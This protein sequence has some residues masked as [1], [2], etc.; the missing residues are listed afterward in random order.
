LGQAAVMVVLK[1]HGIAFS[2]LEDIAKGRY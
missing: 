2:A 1:I